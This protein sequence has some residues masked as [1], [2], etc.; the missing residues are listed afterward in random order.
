[1]YSFFIENSLIFKQ[2]DSCINQLLSI[3]HDIYQCLDQ[4]YEVP[5]LLLDIS[6]AFD[7][8]RYKGL[9]YKLE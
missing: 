3:M 4:G 1:M 9:I 8:F 7:K 5:G 2:R 6:K